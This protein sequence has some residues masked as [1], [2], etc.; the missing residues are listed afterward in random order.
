MRDAARP[1]PRWAL[2]P[3]PHLPAGQNPLLRDLDWDYDY[4]QQLKSQRRPRH[5]CVSLALLPRLA[6]RK[7]AQVLA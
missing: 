6:R 5:C 1:A 3:S 2:P 7:M 4:Q